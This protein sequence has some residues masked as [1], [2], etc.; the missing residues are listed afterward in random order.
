M[1]IPDVGIHRTL[2]GVP[3]D[4][5]SPG[6]TFGYTQRNGESRE[7]RVRKIAASNLAPFLQDMLGSC[8]PARPAG[9]HRRDVIVRTLPD[10]IGWQ[11][12][13]TD[14]EF[15]QGLMPGTTGTLSVAARGGR[16]IPV[17]GPRF[18]ELILACHYQPVPYEVLEDATVSRFRVPELQRFVTREIEYAVESLPVPG[19][20]YRWEEA[21]TDSLFEPPPRM[22]NTATLSY[23]WHN[24]PEPPMLAIDTLRGYVNSRDFDNETFDD[25]VTGFPVKMR[26]H[27]AE[28]LLFA[29][30]KIESYKDLRGDWRFNV[31]YQFLKRDNGLRRD[32]GRAGWN[33]LFRPSS[34]RFERV[35]DAATGDNGIYRVINFDLLF[36][37]ITAN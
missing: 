36:Q 26:K 5:L 12:W 21:P 17:N 11:M 13:C 35:V 7:T 18:N 16:N 29:G 8:Q 3:Y 20:A 31:H 30:A 6:Y 4:E 14:V 33:H 27:A 2:S 37:P 34:Q 23:T 32:G 15:V 1:V 10:T 25:G 19:G 22:L 24:V 28:T 9:E